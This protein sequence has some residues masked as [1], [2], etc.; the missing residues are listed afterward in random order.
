M[1]MMKDT[2]IVKRG[3]M[4][5]WRMTSKKWDYM[6]SILYFATSI[7]EIF[8]IANILINRAF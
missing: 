3:N 7:K 8:F 2:R 5:S 1:K 6:L 4:F